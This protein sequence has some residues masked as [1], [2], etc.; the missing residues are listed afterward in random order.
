MDSV[1]NIA[2]GHEYNI[3]T[4]KRSKIRFAEKADDPGSISTALAVKDAD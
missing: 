3:C 1:C 2:T 4:L